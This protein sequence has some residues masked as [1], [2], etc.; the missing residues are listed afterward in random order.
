MLKDF[1][2]NLRDEKDF[3]R[4]KAEMRERDEIERL[5]HITKKKIEMEM[6]REE[7]I[8]AQEKQAKKNQKLVKKMKI[9]SDKRAEER[10]KVLAEDKEKRA[11]VVDAVHSLK[12]NARLEMEQVKV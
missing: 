12:D 8:I 11:Q 2:M 3:E 6:A 7:A 10:E 1:E 4:W 5:E 9:E